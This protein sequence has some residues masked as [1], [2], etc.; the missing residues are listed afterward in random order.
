GRK[1]FRRAIP[2]S[3]SS[4]TVSRAGIRPGCSTGSEGHPAAASC[5]AGPWLAVMAGGC[6]ALEADRRLA[7]HLLRLAEADADM[8]FGCVAKAAD[9]HHRQLRGLEQTPG[10]GLA[11]GLDRG[12]VEH[13]VHAPLRAAS[14]HAV[15]AA[16]GVEED[17]APRGVAGGDVADA[18]AVLQR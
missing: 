11:I 1:A 14:R 4:I 17:R 10:E 8:A 15:Q 6:E 7:Q 3:A 18:V 12:D 13:H 5:G 2:T 16:D 9:G